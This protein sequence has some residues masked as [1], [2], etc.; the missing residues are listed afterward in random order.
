[1]AKKDKMDDVIGIQKPDPDSH[2]RL[3][4]CPK[5]AG[6]NVAYVQYN[7]RVAPALPVAD[8]AE[9]KRVQRSASDAAAPPARR[10][11]GTAN[12][13]GGAA[14]RVKCFDCSYT[15]DKGNKVKHD[16]QLAWNKEVKS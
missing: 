7:G 1:M 4:A 10:T 12:G 8:E 2:W 13:K 3:R 16:A 11:P 9:Q 5:C 6:D 15:V 14:W